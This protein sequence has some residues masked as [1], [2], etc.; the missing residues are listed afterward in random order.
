M[1]QTNLLKNC[2]EFSVKSRLRTIED[3]NKK[4]NTFES[5]NALDEVRELVLNAF[6]GWLFPIKEKQGK[7][8]KLLFPKQMVERLTIALTCF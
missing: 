5:A 1:D 8:L 2:E 3:R 6:K 4:R 7:G